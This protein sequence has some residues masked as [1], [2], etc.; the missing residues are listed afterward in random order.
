MANGVGR[1]KGILPTAVERASGFGRVGFC[2]LCAHPGAQF[3]NAHIVRSDADGNKLNATQVLGYM[4]VLDPGFNCDRHTIYRHIADHLTSPLV[5]AAQNTKLNGPKILP[6]TNR[7]SLEMIRDVGMQ[8]IIE[9]PET[10]TAEHTIRAIDTMEKKSRGPEEI[11]AFISRVQAGQAPEL[12][13]GDWKELETKPEE[14]TAQ[15]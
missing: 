6:K 11:W 5:T 14:A 1:P 12:V 9:H 2:K 10:I 7:E 8:N 3:L 13:V 4:R 15:P